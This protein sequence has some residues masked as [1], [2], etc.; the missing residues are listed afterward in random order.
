VSKTLRLIPALGAVL[1]ALVGLTA[2][3]GGGIPGNAVAQVNGK[4]I[5]TSTFKHWIRVASI[6]TASGPLAKNPVPPEPPLYTACI[7][8]LK[9]VAE[10]PAT[11]AARS[12]LG[13]AHRDLRAT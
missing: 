7:A 4:P 6:S 13:D 2:C 12:V 10:K 8:H 1:F 9:E 3:G 11:E 5:T